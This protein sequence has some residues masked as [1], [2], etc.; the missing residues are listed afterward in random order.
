MNIVQDY[1]D[2]Q[3]LFN[4]IYQM[5]ELCLNEPRFGCEAVAEVLGNW[6]RNQ[7]VV[8][9]RIWAFHKVENESFHAPLMRHD[10][11]PLPMIF[12]D[13]NDTTRGIL[14]DA[15]TPMKWEYH[16]DVI[17]ETAHGE[18]CVYSPAL[19]NGVVSKEQWQSIFY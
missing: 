7:M 3:K 15:S 9:G 13:R 14:E 19:F 6:L 16:V 10:G 8:T 11:T 4:S 12:T 5:S 1:L 18:P 2:A 17:A